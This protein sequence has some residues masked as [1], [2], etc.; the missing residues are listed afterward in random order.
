MIETHGNPEQLLN[1]LFENLSTGADDSFESSRM[2]LPPASRAPPHARRG[3]GR[4]DGGERDPSYRR[5]GAAGNTRH[6]SLPRVFA[7]EA[8]GGGEFELGAYS[9]AGQNA[10]LL[11]TDD[12]F[13]FE[14]APAIGSSGDAGGSTQSLSSSG[15]IG[16]GSGSG[17][18]SL[19]ST[20]TGT[21]TTGTGALPA[22]AGVRRTSSERMLAP[23][24]PAIAQLAH[25]PNQHFYSTL[26]ERVV[27]YI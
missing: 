4:G 27:S 19:N 2:S 3:G 23:A 15:P 22:V 20:F 9:Y 14:T 21:G 18:N 8:A 12:P 5:A 26:H 11:G 7:L 24:L 13:L 16:G 10:D 17:N 1:R 6:S 25:E